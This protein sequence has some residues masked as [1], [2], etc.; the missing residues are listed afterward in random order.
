[1]G[2]EKKR[3]KKGGGG[4]ALAT[5]PS[6]MVE[7]QK[8]WEA[9]DDLRAMARAMAVKADPARMKRACALA[10]EKMDESEGKKK[11]AEMLIKMGKEG[12]K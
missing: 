4:V 8:R 10:K 3:K 7:D 11:E 1:M 2:Y 5:M 9:E 12:M 6:N